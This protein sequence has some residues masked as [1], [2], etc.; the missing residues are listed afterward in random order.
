MSQEIGT[1]NQLLKRLIIPRAPKITKGETAIEGQR[2]KQQA[3]KTT[4]C[5]N[6]A[7]GH[8]TDSQQVPCLQAKS[9]HSVAPNS[10]RTI[11]RLDHLDLTMKL[12]LVS[13]QGP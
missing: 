7:S 4:M 2:A 13:H 6:A 9:T 10:K 1:I 11:L 3:A 8:H 12:Y 5:G